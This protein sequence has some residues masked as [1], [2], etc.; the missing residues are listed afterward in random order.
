MERC[1]DEGT[2][3][4]SQ[5]AARNE[6][7]PQ[8][9][10]T[11]DRPWFDLATVNAPKTRVSVFHADPLPSLLSFYLRPNEVLF[12]MHPEIWEQTG[13]EHMGELRA[14]P[15]GDSIRVAATAST[16]TVFV[17]AHSGRVP[18]H[19]LKLHFPPHISRFSRRLRYKNIRNS[20]AI[21]RD[22]ADFRFDKFAYLPDTLG[23]TFGADDT[24]WGF[25]VRE[26]TARPARESTFLIPC[27]ALYASD[28]SSPADPPLLI[29]MIRRF[30]ADPAAFVVD[31]I[32]VPVIECWAR[33]ARQRGILLESHAQN[34]LLEVDQDFR[35]TRIVHRDF[36]VWVDSDVRRRLGLDVP[37]YKVGIGSNHSDS[38][39]QHYSLVYDH[40][41]GR[42]FFN[43]LLAVLRRH[44]D[45]I[46]EALV[47]ARVSDA[48]HRS[49]PDS[50]S[51]F[52]AHTTFYFSSEPKGEND[53]PLVDTRQPPEWR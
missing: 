1:V 35:P 47:R 51:F 9:Q 33:V 46:D 15:R 16:R 43:C 42:E 11:D 49:F 12:A 3:S 5:F 36:D 29:Q 23:F 25:L 2:K 52:P 44:F 7:A 30:G 8:Y 26:L 18:R 13:I 41:I 10:A 45:G 34:T 20:I 48:F 6:A 32:M 28:V 22:L 21:T 27:F 19:F 38:I 40:F 24:A 31:H 4:Y 50:R 39:E 14:F 53:F 17:L 37:F